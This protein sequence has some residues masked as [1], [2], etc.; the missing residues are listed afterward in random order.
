MRTFTISVF[1]ISA[2]I[3]AGPAARE[4]EQTPRIK[5]ADQQQFVVWDGQEY[6]PHKF[7][8]VVGVFQNKLAYS[9]QDEEWRWTAHWGEKDY[10]PFD[11]LMVDGVY[12]SKLYFYYALNEDFY[13]QWGEK[14]RGP[15]D[16]VWGLHYDTNA[17][18][19]YYS[20]RHR[21]LS[22]EIH[23]DGN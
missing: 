3:I 2:I 4:I 10:G 9:S 6:G 1:L 21:Q 13:V 17:G 12:Q 18:Q 20:M 19:A 7:V 14:K 5:H 8:I 11:D 23:W 15:Y 16:W 22:L